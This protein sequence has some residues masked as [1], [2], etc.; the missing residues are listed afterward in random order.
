MHVSKHS[1]WRFFCVYGVY[2]VGT[3]QGLCITGMRE[4]HKT[5]TLAKK[6]QVERTWIGSRSE[7]L[8]FLGKHSWRFIFHIEHICKQISCS[9]FHIP[10]SILQESEHYLVR[11]VFL[12]NCPY[13]ELS[14]CMFAP[15]FLA[16]YACPYFLNL[17]VSLAPVPWR[18]VNGVKYKLKRQKCPR[19]K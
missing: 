5:L 8:V 15:I 2:W 10:R 9:W 11:R 6:R 12:H 7:T 1:M 17:K 19:H 13:F 14:N 3:K 18:R 16:L 4:K